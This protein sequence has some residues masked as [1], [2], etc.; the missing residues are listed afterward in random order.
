M[1]QEKHKDFLS[2]T[3]YISSYGASWIVN[4]KFT[5]SFQVI[6]S[7]PGVLLYRG[8]LSSI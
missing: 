7:I 5:L 1:E 2:H 6:S 3:L 8:R 4:M